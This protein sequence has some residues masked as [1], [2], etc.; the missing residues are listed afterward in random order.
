[1]LGIQ[2][3]KLR[4]NTFASRCAAMHLASANHAQ[5]RPVS[6]RGCAC[7]NASVIPQEHC[8]PADGY[9]RAASHR[10]HLFR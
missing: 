8:P 1:M 9:L 3:P 7:N 10:G 2:S 5:A 4:C 6:C